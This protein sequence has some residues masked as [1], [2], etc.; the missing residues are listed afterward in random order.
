MGY[1]NE[2][3]TTTEPQQVSMSTHRARGKWKWDC[4]QL[5][6]PRLPPAPCQSLC[7]AEAVPSCHSLLNPSK[8]IQLQGCRIPS[9][10]PGITEEQ[11]VFIATVHGSRAPA[12]KGQKQNKVIIKCLAPAASCLSL[13]PE[14]CFP[15]G[16]GRFCCVSG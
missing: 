5:G 7:R 13:P 9:V 15:S 4:T 8:L 12:M 11:K 2:T 10:P 3:A 1:Y 14:M 16:S 6:P